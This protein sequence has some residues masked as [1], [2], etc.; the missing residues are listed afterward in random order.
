MDART[1]QKEIETVFSKYRTITTADRHHIHAQ[2]AGKLYELW[3]LASLIEEI[4]A[5]GYSV[6]FQGSTLRFKSAPGYLKNKDPHFIIGGGA[7]SPDPWR[8]FVDV[9]FTTLSVMAPGLGISGAIPT[10]AAPPPDHSAHYEADIIVTTSSGPRPSPNDTAIVIECKAHANLA[11][12]VIREILGTRREL[13]LLSPPT[14]S[15]LP[16]LTVGGALSPSIP[17]NP[18]I[19]LRLV[20]TDS[21]ATRYRQGPRYYGVELKV[22]CP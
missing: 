10:A 13:S 6:A 8:I 4:T 11:K 2:T 16:D 17:A 3:V 22:D 7:P 5:R 15:C 9:E 12:G 14:P 18:P 21:K 20:T 1:A 19:E